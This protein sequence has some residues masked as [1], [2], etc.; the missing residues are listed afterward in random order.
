[1]KKIL[2]II[3]FCIIFY[4]QGNSQTYFY[5][6]QGLGDRYIYDSEHFDEPREIQV[7]R[8]GVDATLKND[9]LLTIYVLDA[10]YAPTFNLFCSTFEMLY[11]DVPCIIVGISN[12][13]R[14]SE[15]TPPYTDYESVKGYDNPGNADSLLLSLKNELIPFIKNR[16]GTSSRIVLAGHSL[17][18]TFVTYAMATNPDLFQCI[19]SVSPN[20]VYSKR[21]MIDKIS[22]FADE[23]CGPHPVYV[24]LANGKKDRLE[25]AF[26]TEIKNAVNILSNHPNIILKNDSL[27]IEKHSHTIFEGYYRGLLKLGDYIRQN[28]ICSAQ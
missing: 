27:N 14:Q 17:G 15:L 7:Y 16:Y 26:K 25:E 11:P 13:N 24:Y 1:M 22:R 2:Y 19:L 21:M 28:N 4:Q 18:G 10:Q 3:L 8:S 23:Y 12:P 9:S 5:S 20:Y 6:M